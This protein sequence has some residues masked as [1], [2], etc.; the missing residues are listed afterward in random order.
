MAINWRDTDERLIRRGERI[1]ELSLVE[2]CQAELDAMN[3]GKES[4]PYKPTPT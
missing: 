1:L 3:H 2:N 4:H